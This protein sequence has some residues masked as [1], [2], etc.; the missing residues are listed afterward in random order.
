MTSATHGFDGRKKFGLIEKV[1]IE[2]QFDV[3]SKKQS[4]AIGVI[5]RAED[6]YLLKKLF[7]GHMTGHLIPGTAQAPADSISGYPGD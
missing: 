6:E 2:K 1:F 5:V 7:H 3:Q 4:L